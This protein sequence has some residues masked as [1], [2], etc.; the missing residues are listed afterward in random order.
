MLTPA[1]QRSENCG[2]RSPNPHAEL[3]MLSDRGPNG[4]VTPLGKVSAPVSAPDKE[5]SVVPYTV[6]KLAA[7]STGGTD[8]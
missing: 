6:I 4:T 3:L 2:M 8:G 5:A 1:F 7:A